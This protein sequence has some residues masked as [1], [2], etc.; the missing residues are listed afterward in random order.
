QL[1]IEPE[2]V[3]TGGVAKNSGVV[4]AVRTNLGVEVSVPD[5]PLISGALGAA[6]LGKDIVDKAREKGETVIRKE[7]R[8]TEA[9]FFRQT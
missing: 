5:D 7:R 8:L 4:K 1:K 9:T 6:L 3:F 2:V